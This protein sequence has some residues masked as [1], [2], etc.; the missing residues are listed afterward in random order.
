MHP[1]EPQR[2]AADVAAVAVR[3]IAAATTDAE[4]LAAWEAFWVA[5]G[6]DAGTSAAACRSMISAAAHVGGNTA[7]V[8]S[9]LITMFAGHHTMPAAGAW[10]AGTDA[11]AATAAAA[12]AAA[13]VAAAGSSNASGALDNAVWEQQL[14]GLGILEAADRV[15]AEACRVEAVNMLALCTV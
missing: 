5:M 4:Q 15:K 11:A 8:L 1:Q 10:S 13:A 9:A 12:T 7:A 3:D 2:N 6:V 14:T